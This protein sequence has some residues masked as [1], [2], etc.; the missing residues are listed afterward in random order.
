MTIYQNRIELVDDLIRILKKFGGKSGEFVAR[1][2]KIRLQKY[3]NDTND[4]V[5]ILVINKGSYVVIKNLD[6]L[7][8]NKVEARKYAKKVN[9]KLI[10]EKKKKK[11][12]ELAEKKR[13]EELEAEVEAE[14]LEFPYSKC[15]DCNVNPK[16][17]GALCLKCLY[18]AIDQA[19]ERKRRREHGITHADWIARKRADEEKLFRL[20]GYND[21]HD[22]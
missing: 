4:Y 1:R 8:V 3:K 18:A 5:P 2:I 17:E 11:A 13:A 22:F 7:D 10:E 15:G 16:P 21:I 12:E 19:V 6:A 9:V 20:C 14:L